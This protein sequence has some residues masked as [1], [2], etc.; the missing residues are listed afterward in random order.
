MNDKYADQR[1]MQH[2]LFSMLSDMFGDEV[3]LYDKSLLVN[4]VCNHTVCDLLSQ[5]HIGFN[6]TSDQ[7][8]KTSGERHGAIRI[9]KP[10]EYRWISR[11]FAVFAMEPHNYYDMTTVGDKSQPIVATAFRS[12]LNPDHRVFSSLLM[13]D[14]FDPDTKARIENLIAT[15]DVFSESAKELIIK[16]ERQGGLEWNDADA[17]ID[18]CIHH[19]FKWTGQARDYQLYTDLCDAGFKIAA[20]IACF[21][22]HH[23]NHLTPNTF[24][25][26]LYTAAMKFCM[27]E[28][29][30]VNFCSQAKTTL[31]VLAQTADRDYLQLH[32]KDLSAEDIDIFQTKSVTGEKVQQL[33]GKLTERLQQTDLN[34]DRLNHAGFKDHTEGPAAGTPILLRQDAYKA[35]SEPVQFLNADGTTVNSVHTAR[36]GEIEER[37]YATTPKGRK[38]YDR[39]LAQVDSIRKITDSNAYAQKHAQLFDPFPKRLE[40]LLKMELV[41]G[42]YSVTEKGVAAKGHI[43]T[44]DINELVRLGYV[45]VEGLRYE[46]FLP[47][48]AAG[49]FASNL[50]QYG[51]QSTAPE[52]PNYSQAM[53]EH[54]LERKIVDANE[55]Y[56]ELQAESLLDVYSQL[57]LDHKLSKN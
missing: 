50:S 4:S 23:L 34:L 11:L 27:G 42:R 57:G 32:F 47:V 54:I 12:R 55:T 51:T 30:E 24:C 14:Y 13:T 37:F 44:T 53:L 21:G 8:E 49:I 17:L 7:I 48:S 41:Y 29:D 3:P 40:E 31:N 16:N 46:D 9:G 15:R 10:S 22:S 36:F 52:K 20:D 25:I 39:C 45:S 56:A 6:L 35:L 38:L 18:E 28:L 19:I 2:R 1:Q 5:I 26:D 43:T 33:V